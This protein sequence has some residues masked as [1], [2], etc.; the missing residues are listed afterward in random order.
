M[1][2]QPGRRRGLVNEST[3]HVCSVGFF[4]LG[5]VFNREPIG[6][7]AGFSLF[8]H[9]FFGFFLTASCYKDSIHSE[10]LRL[11]SASQYASQAP[12]SK[13]SFHQV[14]LKSLHTAARPAAGN[15]SEDPGSWCI[16]F[17]C[18]VSRVAHPAFTRCCS[19]ECSPLPLVSG[20]FVP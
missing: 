6:L 19:S 2:L 7:A 1:F 4:L 10:E 5:L 14:H 13:C 3:I 18:T 12:F 9:L 8:H 20:S 11:R 16:D 17:P 15:K